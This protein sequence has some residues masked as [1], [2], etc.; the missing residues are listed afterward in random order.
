[1]FCLIVDN[2]REYL[3][4]SFFLL[5]SRPSVFKRL[6]ASCYRR[7]INKDIICKRSLWTAG[8][9]L[10]NTDLEDTFCFCLSAV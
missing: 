6:N 8:Q 10:A 2:R 3:P 7:L 4:K 1:M 9:F 5:V